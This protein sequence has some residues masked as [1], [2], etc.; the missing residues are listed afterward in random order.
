MIPATKGSILEK[1]KFAIF[2]LSRSKIPSKHVSHQSMI[3]CY[4][5]VINFHLANFIV[6]ATIF[7]SSSLSVVYATIMPGSYG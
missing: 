7:C 5:G 4:L 1:E 2:S 3:V 6:Y